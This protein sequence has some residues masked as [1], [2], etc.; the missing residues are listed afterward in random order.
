LLS[1][2]GELVDAAPFLLE[3]FFFFSCWSFVA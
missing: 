2:V 3:L 1:T